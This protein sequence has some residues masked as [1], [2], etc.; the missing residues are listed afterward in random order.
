MEL[1]IPSLTA[2][3]ILASVPI[4]AVWIALL[5]STGLWSDLVPLYKQYYST[6]D[7]YALDYFFIIFYVTAFLYIVRRLNQSS[8]PRWQLAIAFIVWVAVLD[9]LVGVFVRSVRSSGSYVTFLRKWADKAGWRAI[10]WDIIY[11]AL[12]MVI[13][14]YLPATWVSSPI[15]WIIISFITIIVLL[16]GF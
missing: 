10:V 9:I 5:K 1:S 11:I 8:R 6:I 4:I 16:V 2:S 7:A 15:F 12:I 3:F 14:Y 13:A